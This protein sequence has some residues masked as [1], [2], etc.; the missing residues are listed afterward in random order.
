MTHSK[1]D[2]SL[3]AYV[4]LSI[5]NS[6]LVA[7]YM[8]AERDVFRDGMLFIPGL[9]ENVSNRDYFTRDSLQSQHNI[10]PAK[11]DGCLYDKNCPT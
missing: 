8:E 5:Y 2:T 3:E 11:R 1:S 9:H 10:I 7:V 4:I 6:I